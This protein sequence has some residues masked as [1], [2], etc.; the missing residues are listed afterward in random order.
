MTENKI[1]NELLGA[2]DERVYRLETP[3]TNN[4]AFMFPLTLQAL[5]HTDR[6][7]GDTYSIDHRPE[8]TAQHASSTSQPDDGREYYS[9]EVSSMTTPR[10]SLL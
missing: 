6:T 5:L 8:A 10:G 3:H 7:R 4:D 2:A 9:K 1:S